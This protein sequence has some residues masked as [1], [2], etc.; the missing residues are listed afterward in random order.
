MYACFFVFSQVLLFFCIACAF[1]GAMGVKAFCDQWLAVW[2]NDGNGTDADGS[3]HD[4]PDQ[5]YYVG[6]YGAAG[7]AFL[8]LHALRGFVYN[9]QL[10]VASSTL[11]NQLMTKLM[12]VSQSQIKTSHIKTSQIRTALPLFPKWLASNI[13]I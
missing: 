11:H 6:V 8:L 9:R 1:F 13:W 4:N 7:A 2:I 5:E 12:H 10:L 3:L